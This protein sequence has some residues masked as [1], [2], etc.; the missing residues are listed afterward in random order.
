[1]CGYIFGANLAE[2]LRRK[3][4]RRGNEGNTEEISEG[5][6]FFFIKESLEEY[7]EKRKNLLLVFLEEFLEKKIRK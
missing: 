1:M 5:I 7:L 2:I 3:N 6:M 4:H